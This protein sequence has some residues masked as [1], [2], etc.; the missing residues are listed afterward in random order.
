MPDNMIP[1]TNTGVT[2]ELSTA[3]PLIFVSMNSI[4][5][6]PIISTANLC[7]SPRVSESTS[8]AP[9]TIMLYMQNMNNVT[10]I[11]MIQPICHPNMG[12]MN[13]S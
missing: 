8:A 2:T 4:Q 13:S 10:A 5:M 11:S 12:K 9:A 7:G 6:M 3:I 1:A